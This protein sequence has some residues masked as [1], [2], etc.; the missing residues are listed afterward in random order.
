MAQVSA[1]HRYCSSPLGSSFSTIVRYHTWLMLSGCHQ[2]VKLQL[3]RWPLLNF[4]RAKEALRCNQMNFEPVFWVH[5][6][7]TVGGQLLVFWETTKFNSSSSVI[8]F[9]C[10][11]RMWNICCAPLLSVVNMTCPFSG[12]TFL[13]PLGFPHVEHS[14]LLQVP[15]SPSQGPDFVPFILC[16]AIQIDE[17]K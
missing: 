15:I 17:F 9:S 11:F 6:K 13:W 5:S 10:Y 14:S 1:S 12:L 8:I 4:G 7:A 3:L 16:G 2:Y